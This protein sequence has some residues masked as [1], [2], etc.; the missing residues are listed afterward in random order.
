MFL[1]EPSISDVDVEDAISRTMSIPVRR[2]I[3]KY[4]KSK[5]G[6]ADNF[7]IYR[8][9]E[10]TNISQMKLSNGRGESEDEK[11][12]LGYLYYAFHVFGL[13]KYKP[14][15]FLK[16]LAKKELRVGTDFYSE[17]GVFC[18]LSAKKVNDFVSSAT[19]QD[20]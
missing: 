12:I 7:T 3:G 18:E 2:K 19:K 8:L 4:T 5:K 9:R 14:E 16:N 20:K 13:K 6:K 11:N 15:D 17:L 1:H 10:L